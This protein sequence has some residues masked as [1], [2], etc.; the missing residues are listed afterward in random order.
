MT[1]EEANKIIT[2]LE[3]KNNLTED[4][5]FEYTEALGFMIK[6]TADP[7]YMMQLGGYYYGQK[8]C[9][10]GPRISLRKGSCTILFSGT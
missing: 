6:T 7:R 1:I 3:R 10:S 4:E 8:T 5:E 2:R 9:I